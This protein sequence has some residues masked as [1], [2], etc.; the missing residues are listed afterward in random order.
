[1]SQLN[2]IKHL[3]SEILRHKNLYYRGKAEVSDEEFDQ[4]EN[5]LRALDPQNYVLDI[6]GSIVYSSDKL[7][8]E[9][10]MLSL[11]KTYKITDLEKWKG[12]DE[13]VS[14]F[15]IDGSSCSLI[16][17]DGLLKLAKTR[18]DGKFGENITNK[19]LC[20]SSIPKK[21]NT[22]KNKLE[23]RGEIYC[24]E[25]QFL[26]LSEYMIEQKLE[27][28]NSLRN[29][30][31]GILGRKENIE[32]ARFLDFQAFELI[33]EEE[34]FQTEKGKFDILKSLDFKTP[35]FRLVKNKKD[36]EEELD[37]AL[38]F[39]SAGNYLID[40]LVFT[41][42]DIKK[43]EELG[44]TAHHPRYKLAY[45]F[46]GE[47]KDS[48]IK[49]ISWQVSRNGILTPVANIKPVEIS[50][51]KVS[52][53][54][55][56]NYGVVKANELKAGDT[57]K[58]VRSGE[59]IPKFLEVV[60]DSGGEVEYPSKCPSC[61]EEID[62]V[63]IRLI[64]TNAICP[65]Q[66]KD[67]ILNFIQK[68]GIEDLS[69]KRLEELIK[70]DLV[71]T[72]DDLYRLTKE[73]LMKLDKIKDK[74]ASK[75][76]NSIKK[77]MDVD[78]ITFLSAL[79]ISGGAYNKCEKVVDAGVN[80]IEKIKE[81][82]VEQLIN[83]DSFAEKS[84]ADFLMSLK[85]KRKLI[86]KLI[87]EGFHFTVKEKKESKKNEKKFCI[88]GTL[89]MK[90]SDLQRIIKDNSGIAVSS[91]SKETD[92]LITNDTQSSSSKFKKAQEL[93]I[94]IINEEKFLEML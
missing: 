48:E 46:Q 76:I 28:P 62:E 90:R 69:S 10:K 58:I 80:T 20:M 54:T 41:Y 74:L 17:E 51:A 15:K 86:D 93:K 73:D 63:D 52:R 77:S 32:L 37:S 68:I 85:S 24:T 2:K 78:L 19:A 94:P 26:K 55:L 27:K 34:I 39:M 18:G 33:S 35:D 44:E 67:T 29:I 66:V 9:K 12:N 5:E 56:H 75:L 89:T 1:M 50:G 3:E 42:N 87:K 21:I 4:L 43:H 31:A 7:A 91:I 83:I 92:F 25:E 81:L 36:I 30:V 11:N 38:D 47:T 16:Y 57:I 6:V 65:A 88:T 45:K 22:Y 71:L 8:H 40:G 53:V 84:A 72:I 23:I 64:C 70:A 13:L 61:E 82:T 79:G 60:Q 59:V 49:T 14:T